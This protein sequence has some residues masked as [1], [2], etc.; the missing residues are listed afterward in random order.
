M[1]P[2]PSRSSLARR[3]AFWALL[4]LVTASAAVSVFWD[5]G[6]WSWDVDE[7]E[8]LQELR[9][10]DTDNPWFSDARS[11]YDRLPRL[12]PLW[13]RCQ[14]AVLSAVPVNER[15]ARLLSAACAVLAVV[16][17]FAW[18]AGRHG[19]GLGFCFAL[20]MCGSPLFLA[21]A[22]QNRYYTM[23]ILA[24][25]L[26]QAAF[27]SGRPATNLAWAGLALAVGTLALFCHTLL[28]AYFALGAAAAVLCL[29]WRWVSAAPLVRSAP[30]IAAGAALY[31]LYLRPLLGGWNEFG[32]PRDTYTVM[33]SF[34][35]EIGLPTLGLALVGAAACLLPETPKEFRWWA[36]LAALTVLFLLGASHVIWFFNYRYALLFFLPFWVLAA[37][38]VL[39]VGRRLGGGPRAL[40]WYACVALLFLPKILSQHQDGSRKDFREAARQLTRMAR[41]EEPVYCNMDTTLRY[42]LA[43]SPVLPWK[44]A[45][46]L[47]EGSCYVALSVNGWDAPL[48]VEG[49]VV[50]LV[51]S[52]GRRRFDE[53]AYLVRVYRMGPRTG[54]GSPG[55]TARP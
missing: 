21:L 9:L 10:R 26:A 49:R 15:N 6:T 51:A 37:L 19:L 11:Q 3:P 54:V 55:A 40:G 18:L 33:A 4:L 20:L 8:T 1:I 48:A 32:E 47:P 27:L 43:T 5:L 30:V 44:G 53:Q 22:Q 2:E 31:L 16:L 25:L 24:Q 28:L 38:G 45:D 35:S 34:A 17:G 23:A 41:P 14:A 52:V 13:Y 46:E 42:Y 36:A 12:I 7:V 39:V 50:E 29:P